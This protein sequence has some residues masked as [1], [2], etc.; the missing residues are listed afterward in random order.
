MNTKIKR[1]NSYKYPVWYIKGSYVLDILYK[2]KKARD[3]DVFW[4]SS[5]GKPEQ[6]DIKN[7]LKA[8]NFHHDLSI[9]FSYVDDFIKSN[10]GG[11]PKINLDYLQLHMDGKVYLA[12]PDE[13][14]FRRIS[15]KEK[16]KIKIIDKDNISPEKARKIINKM[17]QYPEIYDE[18]VKI[19]LNDIIK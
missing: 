17:E 7:W 18:A 12:N 11:P 3:I 13:K 14:I 10:G 4:L 1:V 16:I 8:H 9:Q 6:N 5:H 2:V 15:A 19:E